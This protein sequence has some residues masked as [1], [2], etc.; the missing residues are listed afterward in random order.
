[1]TIERPDVQPVG[2]A[3]INPASAGSLHDNLVAALEG[4]GRVQ[5]GM[6]SFHALWMEERRRYKALL[7]AHGIDDTTGTDGGPA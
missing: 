3:E 1:M 5:R 4:L 7:A 6:D 2:D